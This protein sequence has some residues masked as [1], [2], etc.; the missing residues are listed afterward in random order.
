MLLEDA[1]EETLEVVHE[2]R[3]PVRRKLAR[4]ADEPPALGHDDGHRPRE[5]GSAARLSAAAGTLPG[6]LHLELV[7][8]LGPVEVLEPVLAQFAQPDALERLVVDDACAVARESSVCPPCASVQIRAARWT[9]TP[10]VAVRRGYGSPVCTPIRARTATSSGQGCCA[11][12]RC[13]SAA[14]ATAARAP[15]ESDEERV[16]LRVDLDASVIGES[17]PHELAMRGEHGP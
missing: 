4:H 12:A 6:A 14:A 15:G 17:L 7:D 11:S 3:D 13:A 8:P 10:G 2:R 16:S 9:D 1:P 5:R